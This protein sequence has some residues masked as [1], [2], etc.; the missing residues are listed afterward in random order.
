MVAENFW[1]H[2]GSANKFSVYVP[3][4]IH[5]FVNNVH[6]IAG[7]CSTTLKGKQEKGFKLSYL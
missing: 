5:R 6:H 7:A 1:L 3:S 4:Y 2:Q